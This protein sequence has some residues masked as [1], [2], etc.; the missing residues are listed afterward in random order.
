MNKFAYDV[1]R[2]RHEDPNLKQRTDLLSRFMLVFHD[3]EVVTE[4]EDEFV[5]VHAHTPHTHT[6][7]HATHTHMKTIDDDIQQ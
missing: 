5:C 2:K 6:H 4:P 1:I 7:T 3:G